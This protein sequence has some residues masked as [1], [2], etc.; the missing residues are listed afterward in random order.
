[1]IDQKQRYYWIKIYDDFLF[2]DEMS[3]MLSQENGSDYALIYLLLCSIFKN[4]DGR[5]ERRFGNIVKQFDIR[6]VYL[7]LKK[8]FSFDTVSIALALFK[9]MGLIYEDKDGVMCISNYGEMIGSETMAARLKRQQRARQLEAPNTP[10]IAT[11]NTETPSGGQNGGHCPPLEIGCNN[12]NIE[13]EGGW[14]L[15][16]Q[17]L[18]TRDNDCLSVIK[19]AR[20]REDGERE[21]YLDCLTD[22]IAQ[23]FTDSPEDMNCF[24]NVVDRLAEKDTLTINRQKHRAA[25]VMAIL[26]WYCIPNNMGE[27]GKVFS[28]VLDKQSRGEVTNFE[29]YLTGA[30][31]NHARNNGATTTVRR[32]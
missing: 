9:E 11:K 4:T 26:L 19:N 25:E 30:L 1:M 6:D 10:Q 7:E 28:G 3:F 23:C 17:R 14:T 22:K 29:T 32:I 13:G 31:Y 5:F 20:A 2:G 24:Q 15:S 21:F 27:F 8:W 16:N 12:I 18:D